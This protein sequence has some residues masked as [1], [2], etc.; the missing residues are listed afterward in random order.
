MFFYI[1]V[2]AAGLRIILKRK[3]LIEDAEY[4]GN[5]K[6]TGKKDYQF[7]YRRGKAKRFRADCLG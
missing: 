2:Y 3:L 1:H 7:D 6:D 5:L 4:N